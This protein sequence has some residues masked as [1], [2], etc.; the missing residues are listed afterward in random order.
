[1]T[2]PHLASHLASRLDLRAKFKNESL[3]IVQALLLKVG[4]ATDAGG[5]GAARPAEHDGVQEQ[6]P[7]EE[8]DSSGHCEVCC[9][10]CQDLL[11]CYACEVRCCA[12]CAIRVGD[13]HQCSACAL[14]A[15]GDE[16]EAQ[17]RAEAGARGDVVEIAMPADW[18]DH[19][20]G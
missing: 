16:A 20:D 1:M 3:S 13:M 14:P 19:V 8:D 5:I 18:M 4:A 15:A 7:A 11:C 17:A 6:E 9:G 2:P 12:R 10:P